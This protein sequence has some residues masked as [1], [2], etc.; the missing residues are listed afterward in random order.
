MK[1]KFTALYSSSMYS[2]RKSELSD[3]YDLLNALLK[4]SD[5]FTD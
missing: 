5:D 1:N 4:D 2:F 3:E